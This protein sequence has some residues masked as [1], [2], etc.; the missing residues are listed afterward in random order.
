[1][2]RLVAFVCL[3]GMMLFLSCT[4]AFAA[5][6]VRIDEIKYKVVDTTDRSADTKGFAGLSNL[7]TSI[8]YG[9]GVLGVHFSSAPLWINEMEIKY[10]V[11]LVDKQGKSSMLTDETRYLLVPQGKEH[12]AYIFMPPNVLNRF[13]E[14]KQIRVETWYNGILED[15]QEWPERSAQ[16]WWTKIQPMKGYLRVKHYTPFERMAQNE[17][18][19]KISA[20]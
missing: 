7:A 2:Q 11:M 15:E 20:N 6:K 10:Y 13:G 8:N 4:T 1:M 9:W 12:M 14:V 18:L 17:E 3:A 19:I 16:P 5:Q